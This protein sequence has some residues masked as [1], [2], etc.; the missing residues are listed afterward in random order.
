L[1]ADIK[2]RYPSAS[3]INNRRVVF[4]IRGNKYRIVPDINYITK[5]VYT[6]FVDTHKE[7]DRIG[8]QIH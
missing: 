8:V 3:I 7:Y 5:V 6:Q 2:A 1:S 4:N